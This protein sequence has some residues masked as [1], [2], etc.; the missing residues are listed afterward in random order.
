MSLVKKLAMEPLVYVPIRIVKTQKTTQS[1]YPI[2]KE[3]KYEICTSN[4]L[5]DGFL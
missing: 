3:I 1:K 5:D 2:T 4:L